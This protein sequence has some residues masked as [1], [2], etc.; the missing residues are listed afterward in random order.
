MGIQRKENEKVKT[1]LFFYYLVQNLAHFASNET[2]NKFVAMA[3]ILSTT[4][5]QLTINLKLIQN[6]SINKHAQMSVATYH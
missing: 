5:L 6:E 3:S 4:K 1:V 2:A